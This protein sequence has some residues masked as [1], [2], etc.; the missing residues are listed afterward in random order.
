MRS[1]LQ[2]YRKVS[3]ESGISVASP[4]KIIQMLFAGALERLAQARCA[5]EQ[6]DLAKKGEA[7]GKAISIVSGLNG[8]LN[9][10]VEGEVANNLNALYDFMLQQMSAANMNNDVK[11]IDD[12]MEILKVI[13]EG[14]DTIPPEMH[15]LSSKQ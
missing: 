10:E 3:V 4:H 11:A 12:V 5:I 15:Q 14:W 8:S 7:I 13:K 1:S 2:S 6:N 9:M